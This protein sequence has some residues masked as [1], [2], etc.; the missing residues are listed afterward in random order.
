MTRQSGPKDPVY[1]QDFE[2]YYV[3]KSTDPTFEAIKTIS[4]AYGN[5]LLFKPVAIY[6]LKDG[7]KG[8]HPV[9]L[10]SQSRARKRPR[11]VV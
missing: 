5:P 6:D 7:L 8:I 1:G 9:R 4:D 3:Y 2:A 11:C 10:G